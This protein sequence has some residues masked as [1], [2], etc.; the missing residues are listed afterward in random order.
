MGM[1]VAVVHDDVGGVEVHRDAHV[2]EAVAVVQP[3]ARLVGQPRHVERLPDLRR[4]REH[5]RPR[6][7]GIG[8]VALAVADAVDGEMQA[9]QMHGVAEIRRVDDAPAHRLAD[10]VRQPLRERPGL[11]VDR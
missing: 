11:A 8:A 5:E 1:I 4:L 3:A 2:W 10:L 7:G 6:V 9:V